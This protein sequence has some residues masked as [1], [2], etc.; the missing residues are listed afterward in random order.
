M[1]ARNRSAAVPPSAATI[2]PDPGPD[3]YRTISNLLGDWTSTLVRRNL[4]AHMRLY[5]PTLQSFMGQSEV[6]TA[7]VRSEA[8][9]FVHSHPDLTTIELTNLQ[10]RQL[11]SGQYVASFVEHVEDSNGQQVERL[12]KRI[13]LRAFDG[14]LRIVRE[15]AAPQ[16]SS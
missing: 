5:A 16:T 1:E 11:D 2:V 14:Q 4:D 13:T 8:E 9:K 3:I 15:D 10:I 7:T 12:R 6:S